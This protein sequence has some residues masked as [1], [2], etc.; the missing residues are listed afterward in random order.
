MVEWLD[1]LGEAQHPRSE[2]VV[3]RFRRGAASA[4]RITAPERVVGNKLGSFDGHS[5]KKSPI[6]LILVRFWGNQVREDLVF[7]W[8][9]VEVAVNRA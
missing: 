2:Y 4:T 8:K 5:Y 7:G 6:P 3:R 1:A 9:Y